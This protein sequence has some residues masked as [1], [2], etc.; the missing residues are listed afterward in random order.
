[1]SFSTRVIPVR[2]GTQRPVG[3]PGRRALRATSTSTGA[4]TTSST[5]PAFSAREAFRARPVRMRSSAVRSPTS[6][7]RRCVPP[8][9][10][11]IPSFTSGRPS[12]VFGMIARPRD[13]GRPAPS[14]GRRPCRSRGWR[15]PPA[16]SAPP[17]GRGWPGPWR[18]SVSP[19]SELRMVVKSLMSAPAMKLSGLPLRR[20]IAA[21]VRA[22]LDLAEERLQLLHHRLA[23]GVDLLAGHVEGEDQ[24]AVRRQ[25]LG[26]G[27]GGG[28][29]RR[30]GHAHA[31]TPAPRI[32]SMSARVKPAS[33]EHGVGV[34]AQRGRGASGRGGRPRA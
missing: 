27:A 12:D 8:M 17:G 24:D 5:I 1:M 25:L 32:F 6:R 4:G 29:G 3:Q 19:S 14:P 33:A 15:P 30:A 18:E 21:H 2:A 10:G 26:E 23:Q 11:M 22:R 20:T 9:P 7:G 31:R 13:S 28:R 16:P 34:L